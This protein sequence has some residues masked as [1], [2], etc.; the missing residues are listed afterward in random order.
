MQIMGEL[1]DDVGN[2]SEAD[3]VLREAIRLKPNDASIMN[4]L[5]WHLAAYTDSGYQDP[6]TAVDLRDRRSISNPKTR[7]T[8]IRWASRNTVPLTIYVRLNRLDKQ[9]CL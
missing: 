7:I 3:Y 9:N 8:G 2:A 4:R 5:A 1:L 6:I